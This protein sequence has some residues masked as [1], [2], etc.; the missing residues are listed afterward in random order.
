MEDD[1]GG[2]RG[3]L[4][5]AANWGMGMGCGTCGAVHTSCVE[6]LWC[7][8]CP[9]LDRT[10]ISTVTVATAII[11]NMIVHI[12]SICFLMLDSWNSFHDSSPEYAEALQ[13]SVLYMLTFNQCVSTSFCFLED[14]GA[15]L[16]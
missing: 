11:V 7:A 15:N 12:L 1:P 10:A 8:S 2:A 13:L 14:S 3:L 6:A 5:R 16:T 9:S 4:S